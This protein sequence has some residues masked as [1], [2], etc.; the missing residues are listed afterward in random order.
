MFNEDAICMVCKDKE[1]LDPDYEKAVEADI[2]QIKQGNYNFEGIRAEPERYI[3]PD[4]VVF[5]ILQI[6]SEGRFNMFAVVDI[7]RE[8]YIN[9]FFE[10]VVFLEEH[11]TQYVN[12]ILTGQR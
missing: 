5:Q 8:A 2:E 10:L 3:I 9:N 6:K 1:K 7:Q 11:K 12:F 4:K